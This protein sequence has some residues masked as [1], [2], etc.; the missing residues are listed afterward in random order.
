MVEQRVIVAI[1]ECLHEKRFFFDKQL[2]RIITMLGLIIVLGIV[3]VAYSFAS[4]PL[5]NIELISEISIKRWARNACLATDISN[6][7]LGK[8][9]VAH[10]NLQSVEYLNTRK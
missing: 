4:V 3:K 2:K 7:Y 9:L 1:F 6:F 10:Q 5:N 8:C